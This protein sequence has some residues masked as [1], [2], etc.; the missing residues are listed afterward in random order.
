[1]VIDNMDKLENKMKNFII[2]LLTNCNNLDIIIGSRNQ[3]QFAD[4]NEAKIIKL[5]PLNEVDAVK[6]FY[7]YAENYSKKKDII[8]CEEIVEFINLDPN[9]K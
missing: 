7:E 8:K 2:K 1:M 9:S 6:L 5:N 4:L 3:N